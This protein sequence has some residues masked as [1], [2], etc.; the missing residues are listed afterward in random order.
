M[1]FFSTYTS[2]VLYR[3]TLDVITSTRTNIFTIIGRVIRYYIT[4]YAF[5]V[6]GVGGYFDTKEG[7]S[8][9]KGEAF[10]D[11]CISGRRYNTA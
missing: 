2:L 8:I 9:S 11:F 1:I 4:E 5:F 7:Y 6:I 3:R 10:F